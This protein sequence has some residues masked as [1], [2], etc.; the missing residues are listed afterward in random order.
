MLGLLATAWL[1]C[2]GEPEPR[3]FV[4]LLG[5]DTLAI[6]VFR[7]TEDGVEGDVLVRS[8]A[9]RAGHYSLTLAEDGSVSRFEVEWWTPPENPDGLPPSS[10]VIEVS[11]DSASIV[12]RGE[13]ESVTE[14]VVAVPH[15]VPTTGRVPL[16]VGLFEYAIRLAQA[17]RSGEDVLGFTMLWPLRGRSSPNS[18]TNRGVGEVALDYFGNPLVAR[19][20]AEGRIESI[21]GSETTMKVE[22]QPIDPPDIIALAADFAARDAQG[23][24]IGAP[25]PRATVSQSA[26][27]AN[28]E[29]VYSRPAMRGREIWGEL[30][31]FNEV[32]R[33]GANAATQFTTDRDLLVGEAEVPAGTYTLWSTYTADTATLIINS[34]TGQWGTQHDAEQDFVRVPMTIDPVSQ[35]LERF[36]IEIVP[37]DEDATLQLTWDRTRF[38]VPLRV[39]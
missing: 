4:E 17:D 24:G 37:D 1:G 33:T 9:T 36:T 21:S 20:D 13:G 11:G 26:G 10:V 23:E 3:A 38:S 15:P 2:A 32:W 31:P 8:P 5:S 35:P 39:R 30:V 28:F 34:Q 16:A 29:V 7:H 14:Q 18:I 22:I 27:G 25:S 6:E 19:F 12:R